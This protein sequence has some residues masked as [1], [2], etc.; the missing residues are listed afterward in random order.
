MIRRIIE[1]FFNPMKTFKINH[2]GEIT[3]VETIPDNYA[4]LKRE[5]ETI[6]YDP[7]NYNVNEHNE[8]FDFAQFFGDV[9]VE[10]N[11][12]L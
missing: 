7:L 5:E 12:N 2:L 11:K 9:Y 4:V 1:Y 3:R 10:T 8:Y 6:Y